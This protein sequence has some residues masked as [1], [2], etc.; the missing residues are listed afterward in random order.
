MTAKEKIQYYTIYDF[1]KYKRVRYIVERVCGVYYLHNASQFSV[2][3]SIRAA[4]SHRR[5]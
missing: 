2:I 1:G 3:D 5:R 4:Y